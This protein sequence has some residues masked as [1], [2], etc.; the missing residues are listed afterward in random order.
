MSFLGQKCCR[1]ISAKVRP[2]DPVPP[3][4][5]IVCELHCTMTPTRLLPF[6]TCFAL[7]LR[8]VLQECWQASE[9]RFPGKEKPKDR[10]ANE[11]PVR[12]LGTTGLG[13]G[14][15]HPAVARQVSLDESR[16]HKNIFT[17]YVVMGIFRLAD[18]PQVQSA[19]PAS[20][21]WRDIAFGEEVR[22]RSKLRQGIDTSCLRLAAKN[23]PG[24]KPGQDRS[25]S[26]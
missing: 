10:R 25:R 9:S 12:P 11:G 7:T 26:V 8:V 21:Q 4:I 3:V 24:A 2:K 18:N 23:S 17:F 19:Q 6:S 20:R 5:K 14:H 16:T 22:F 1:I 13:Y 15:S